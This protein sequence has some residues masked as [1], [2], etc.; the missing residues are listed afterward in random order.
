MVEDLV[1]ED[2]TDEVLMTEELRVPDRDRLFRFVLPQH[3]RKG[4]VLSSSARN[5]EPLAQ[6]RTALMAWFTYRTRTITACSS[7]SSWLVTARAMETGPVRMRN[8]REMD[9][10]M[11]VPLLADLLNA[12]VV[13]SVPPPPLAFAHDAFRNL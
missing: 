4:Y 10:N 5:L 13:D 2:L 11:A 1:A 9:T 7:G 6:Y 8:A 12:C 3:R